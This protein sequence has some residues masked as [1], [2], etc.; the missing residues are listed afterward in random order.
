[1]SPWTTGTC[2]WIS[3]KASVNGCDQSQAATTFMPWFNE[4]HCTDAD[5]A[6]QL[7]NVEQIIPV[8]SLVIKSIRWVLS[9]EDQEGHF[10]QQLGFKNWNAAAIMRNC[11]TENLGFGTTR[12]KRDQSSSFAER[13]HICYY[14]QLSTDGGVNWKDP[15]A[16]STWV[17]PNHGTPQ[18]A[19]SKSHPILGLRSSP[20]WQGIGPQSSTSTMMH[21]AFS[22]AT[23]SGLT[24][25]RVFLLL[26]ARLSGG[27]G[28][29]RLVTTWFGWSENQK[30]HI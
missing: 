23:P 2:G 30:K 6:A 28:C 4:S 20:S 12:H 3:A 24:D 1:M 19:C 14:V 18:T 11:H 7:H 8:A 17:A 21:T 27:A 25:S 26:S 29:S 10:V 16:C 9:L 22:S 15:W 13:H 5:S